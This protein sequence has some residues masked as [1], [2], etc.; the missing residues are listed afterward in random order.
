M[1]SRPPPHSPAS[2]YRLSH[3]STS[4]TF[5]VGGNFDLLP[6]QHVLGTTVYTSTLLTR[7][8][9]AAHVIALPFT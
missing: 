5:R 6:L 9:T 7:P 4:R 2:L 8:L 3:R 1:S